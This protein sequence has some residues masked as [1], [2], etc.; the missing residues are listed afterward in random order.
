MNASR[1]RNIVHKHAMQYQRSKTFAD[2]KKL[3]K[4]G[5]RKHKGEPKAP[6]CAWAC[7]TTPRV[8]FNLP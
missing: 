3:A 1:S 6:P 8:R 2:R 7:L 4:K 5:Y